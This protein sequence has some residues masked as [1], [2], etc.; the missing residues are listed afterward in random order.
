[1]REQWLDIV[2][3]FLASHGIEIPDA[4]REDDVDSLLPAEI[5]RDGSHTEAWP[6]LHEE[7]THTYRDLDRTEAHRIMPDPDDAE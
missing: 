7:M 3:P 6:E 4:V 1:M 5:G 2:V